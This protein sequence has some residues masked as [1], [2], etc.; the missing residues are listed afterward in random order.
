MKSKA[1]QPAHGAKAKKLYTFN[2]GCSFE[3]QYTFTESQ[4]EP[5]HESDEGAVEPTSEA[6]RELEK[7]LT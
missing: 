4:V 7:E 1:K 3:L 5:D 6:I 2:V